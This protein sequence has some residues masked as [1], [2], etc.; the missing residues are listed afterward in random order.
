MK[1]TPET[2]DACCDAIRALFAKVDH[3]RHWNVSG[4]ALR[5]VHDPEHKRPTCIVATGR[6]S[7]VYTGEATVV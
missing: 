7:V 4:L 3:D 5:E 6:V 1:T 2:V